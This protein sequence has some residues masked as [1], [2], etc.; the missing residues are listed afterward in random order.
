MIYCFL[1]GMKFLHTDFK[2]QLLI[3]S[4]V[5]GSVD[6]AGSQCQEIVC[7]RVCNI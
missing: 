6:L 5:D 3:N 7:M 2:P 1:Y 4:I